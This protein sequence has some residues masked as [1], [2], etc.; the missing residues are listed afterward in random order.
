MYFFFMKQTWLIWDLLKICR[1][2]C[3]VCLGMCVCTLTQAEFLLTS[4][5]TEINSLPVI[6][7]LFMTLG[8]IIMT[9]RTSVPLAP[10]LMCHPMHKLDCILITP[11][12][13]LIFSL[14]YIIEIGNKKKLGVCKDGFCIGKCFVQLC[15]RLILE[16]VLFAYGRM[17][18]LHPKFLH[19]NSL[20]W[21]PFS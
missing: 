12:Y 2:T 5:E 17:R 10:V 15:T 21:H 3:A 7:Q 6:I 19:L 20:S 1:C 18:S 4:L 9:F 16:L 14:S 11:F 13:M 8:N